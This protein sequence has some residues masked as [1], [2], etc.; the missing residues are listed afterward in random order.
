MKKIIYLLIAMVCMFSMVA[1]NNTKNNNENNIS[2][3]ANQ[4]NTNVNEIQKEDSTKKTTKINKEIRY[5]TLFINDIKIIE[6][7]T[8]KYVLT[9]MAKNESQA[10]FY[11]TEVDIEL[12]NNAGDSMGIVGAVIPEIKAGETAEIKVSIPLDV[13]NTKDVEVKAPLI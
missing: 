7:G 1:C 3:Q 10:D 5:E 6:E 9:A 2:N 13:M 11:Q 4:G 12:Y 8:D